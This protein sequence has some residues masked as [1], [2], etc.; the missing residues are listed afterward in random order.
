ML[1]TVRELSCLP[2]EK[3]DELGLSHVD[4]VE[5]CQMKVHNYVKSVCIQARLKALTYFI[6][7]NLDHLKGRFPVGLLQL[8][9]VDRTRR[10]G[11]ESLLKVLLVSV[12]IMG[13]WK[14]LLRLCVGCG[15]IGVR[16]GEFLGCVRCAKPKGGDRN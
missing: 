3:R 9:T 13:W 15:R 4:I 6:L 2:L 14:L 7:R 16:I 10:F 5:M 12:D 11:V 1:L 8:E